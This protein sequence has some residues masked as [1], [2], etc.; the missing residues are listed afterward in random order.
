MVTPEFT[1]A[2][3]KRLSKG[4][5][6]TV[7]QA[8]AQQTQYKTIYYFK[9]INRSGPGFTQSQEKMDGNVL[10]KFQVKVLVPQYVLI[11][12]SKCLNFSSK[13]ALEVG[14]ISSSSKARSR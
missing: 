3:K 12:T 2:G 11:Q 7:L 9:R 8:L 10:N 14:E 13:R 6:S 5:E 4:V 1:M